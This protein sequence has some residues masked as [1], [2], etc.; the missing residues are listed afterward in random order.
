MYFHLAIT[1]II[2][3]VFVP[4]FCAAKQLPTQAP[5]YPH[6]GLGAQQPPARISDENRGAQPLLGSLTG[7]WCR[8]NWAAASRMCLSP[9]TV[10][11][12]RWVTQ[13]KATGSWA[14]GGSDLRQQGPLPAF[15]TA[16][17]AALRR[18]HTYSLATCRTTASRRVGH[19]RSATWDTV[20][21][22]LSPNALQLE[23]WGLL[24]RRGSQTS[25]GLGSPGR[26]V[27]SEVAGPRPRAADKGWGRGK[28]LY[29]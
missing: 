20:V 13:G 23:G 15:S 7:R 8:Q 18:V 4:P 28:S 10:R 24:K 21:L 3:P 9:W 16:T 19:V 27:D 29:L 6:K 2:Q 22:E 1:N 11:L 25:A 14:Q 26:L 5:V 12:G 17:G